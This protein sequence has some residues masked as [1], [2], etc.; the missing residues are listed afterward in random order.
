M[1]YRRL[2]SKAWSLLV[3][4]L[5]LAVAIAACGSTPGAPGA[6]RSEELPESVPGVENELT[7][8]FEGENCLYDGPDR[9]PA[10]RSRLVLDVRDQVAH[11]GYAVVAVTLEAGKTGEDLRAWPSADT[12]P[13]T[14]GHGAVV[15]PRGELG[16]QDVTLHEASLFLVCFTGDPARKIDLLGPI[17]VEASTLQAGLLSPG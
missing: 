7:V 12:P 6:V 17:E 3:T 9:V 4:G 2:S 10:G 8:T 5:V 13:W 1:G 16:W 15:V 14:H 11:A